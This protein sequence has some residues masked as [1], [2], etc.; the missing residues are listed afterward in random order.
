MD[1]ED[2][3][4]LQIPLSSVSE[5]DDDALTDRLTMFAEYVDLTQLFPQED[6]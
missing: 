2:T 5:S 3:M 1:F 4:P 6:Y